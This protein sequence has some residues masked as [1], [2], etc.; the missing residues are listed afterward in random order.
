MAEFERVERTIGG[1]N[2]ARVRVAVE[3]TET[4]YRELVG[5]AHEKLQTQCDYL[6][7]LVAD[8][9]V[10]EPGFREQLSEWL[11]HYFDGSLDDD[12]PC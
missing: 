6:P 12:P 1:H 3:L 2:V 5:W 10:H 7:T 9:I 11:G 4:T 8:M